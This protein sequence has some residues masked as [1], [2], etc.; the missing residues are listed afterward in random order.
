L[1]EALGDLLTLQGAY[2][3]AIASYEA[4]AAFDPSPDIER[5]LGEVH[6]RLG[7]WDAAD[8]HYAE[9]G[10]DARVLADRSLNAHRAGRLNDARAL[11]RRALKAAT[12]DR[13]LARAHNVSGIVASHVGARQE[14]VEHLQAS[15][16]LAEKLNDPSAI[17]AALNNLALTT[18]VVERAL[19][20]EERALELCTRI[21]DRHREAAL[22]SNLA[23]LLRAAGRPEEAVEH[24]KSSAAIF[25]GVG[26][27]DELRPEVWKLVE[28]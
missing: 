22:H 17:V 5:K 12:D 14:A 9:A 26:S 4:A 25:A 7:D 21:G 23:D 11:A 2:R 10:D 3:E 8:A 19:E 24:I 15:L 6:H 18:D 13:S 28:W 16:A 1:H 20:L 27:P